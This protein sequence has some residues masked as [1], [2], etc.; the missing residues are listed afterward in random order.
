M[1]SSPIIISKMN[2]KD[3]A[4]QKSRFSC[5]GSRI[6]HQAIPIHHAKL[7]YLINATVTCMRALLYLILYALH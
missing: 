6:A 4:N 7:K 5:I 3:L 2:I 1:A